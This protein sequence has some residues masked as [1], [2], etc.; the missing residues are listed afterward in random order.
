M[1]SRVSGGSCSDAYRED[2][3]AR[4]STK[5]LC[6]LCGLLGI[7]GDDHTDPGDARLSLK[8]RDELDLLNTLLRCTGERHSTATAQHLLDRFGS[9][10]AILFADITA[11]QSSLPA[12]PAIAALLMTI[13]AAVSY[14]L[15]DDMSEWVNL[16]N[17]TALYRYVRATLGFNLSERF[18]VLYL[19]SACQLISNEV[20]GIGTVTSVD[21]YPREIV[22]RALEHG[23]TAMILLHNHP[24]GDPRPSRADIAMTRN[25][26]F[27]CNVFDLRV[28]DH[29]IVARSG[30]ASFHEL[31]LM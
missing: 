1:G 11:L 14:A 6:Q 16:E 13:S 29:L 12:T 10:S 30:I 21:V 24:S 23:A 18:H 27:A 5:G 20:M 19:N 9:L 31:G 2:D 15:A 17:R 7:P 22:R 3:R 4:Y 8:A 26:V 25:I 28:H